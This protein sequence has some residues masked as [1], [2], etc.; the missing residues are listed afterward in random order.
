[1]ILNPCVKNN[2]MVD[3]NTCKACKETCSYAGQPITSERIKESEYTKHK[4]NKFYLVDDCDTL[5][6]KLGNTVHDHYV[7]D[8]KC[9][10]IDKIE[11]DI[12]RLQDA[13]DTNNTGVMQELLNEY[14]QLFK[15]YR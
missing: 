4:G 3:E 14:S 1:M 5:V 15:R 6:C 2:K 11:N 13:I 8:E 10:N 9:D 12:E 7:N